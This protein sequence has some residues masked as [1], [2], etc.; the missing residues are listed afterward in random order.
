MITDS[1]R[2]HFH[3]CPV[4]GPHTRVP[5][6]LVADKTREYVLYYQHKCPFCSQT[7]GEPDFAAGVT[8][9]NDGSF[10]VDTK[11]AEKLQN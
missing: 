3:N 2:V 6:A 7:A 9:N 11:I 4:L 1:N 5:M 10:S 8:Q